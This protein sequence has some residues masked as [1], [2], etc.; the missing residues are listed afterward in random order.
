MKNIRVTAGNVLLKMLPYKPTTVIGMEAPTTKRKPYDEA[1]VVKIGKPDGLFEMDELIVV[2][3][4]F[5]VPQAQKQMFKWED[6]EE[7]VLVYH[8]ELKVRLD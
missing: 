2:G 5:M 6:G 1:V 8:R 7:Y 3:A 4:K